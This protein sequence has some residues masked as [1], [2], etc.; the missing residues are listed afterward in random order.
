MRYEYYDGKRHGSIVT[1]AILLYRCDYDGKCYEFTVSAEQQARCPKWDMQNGA[2]PPR[3]AAEALAKASEFIAAIRIADDF[4]WEL[5]E[6]A[7][8]EIKGWMWQARYCLAKR[9]PSTG[10]WPRMP[11]WI[12]MDGTV[13]QPRITE[14]KN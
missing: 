7:L 2:N 8:V 10:V 4:W 1:T 14:I 5:E 13:I 12:L 11:C 6:L 9:G 3:S